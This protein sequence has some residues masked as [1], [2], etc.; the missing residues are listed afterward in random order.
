MIGICLSLFPE[1]KKKKFIIHTYV[2]TQRAHRVVAGSA[3]TQ[4]FGDHSGD[5]ELTSPHGGGGSE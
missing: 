5:E 4:G 3:P 2:Q 1:I